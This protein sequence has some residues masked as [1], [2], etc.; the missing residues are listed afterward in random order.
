VPRSGYK[1]RAIPFETRVQIAMRHGC[2]P[3]ETITVRCH[4]CP[5][6]GDIYWPLVGRGIPDKP[7]RWVHFGLEL[8]HVIPE[9]MGGTNAPD[10][11]VLACRMC[12]RSK[13]IGKLPKRRGVEHAAH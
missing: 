7:G 2:L 9:F 6:T 1:K 13:G 11:I 3:G 4:Y 5:A 12:N 8:D 10:N